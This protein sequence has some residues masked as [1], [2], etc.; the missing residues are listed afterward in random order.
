MI[1][2][3]MKTKVGVVYYP[4]ASKKIQMVLG[5]KWILVELVR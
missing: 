5:V 3:I 2:N 4:K 1:K